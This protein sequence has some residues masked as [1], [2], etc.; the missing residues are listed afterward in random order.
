MEKPNIIKTEGKKREAGK[1]EGEKRRKEGKR[2]MQE[3]VK[4]TGHLHLLV[5]VTT[6]GWRKKLKNCLSDGEKE[7]IRKSSGP[8]TVLTDEQLEN[9]EEE[10]WALQLC[11]LCCHRS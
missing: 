2:G 6:D 10:G 3:D 11:T 8:H 5:V 4:S 9:E 1:R 7:D